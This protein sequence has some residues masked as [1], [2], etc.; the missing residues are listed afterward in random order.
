MKGCVLTLSL[1]LSFCG[2]SKTLIVD[3]KGSIPSIRHAI[4]SASPGDTIIVRPG[5][6]R[7]GNLT[8]N[9]P[10][11][12][13]GTGFPVLDGENKYEIMTVT[14]H[15]VT[16]T[17]F[18]L[19]NTGVASMQDV[20]AISSL[21]V[22]G[23]RII[24]NRFENTFFG[25][26]LAG[27]TGCLIENNTLKSNAESEHQLGNGIHCWK[28]DHIT[29]RRNTISGHRDGIY[30]EFVTRS[31]IVENQS[32]ENGRYGLHFM[33]SHD[34]EYLGNTFRNNGAGVAV[35]YS[36][37][38]RMVGNKFEEN[39]SASAYGLLLKDISDSHIEKNGFL[40]NTIG[41]HMEGSSR[42]NFTGN[43]FARNGWAIKIQ[44]SCEQNSYKENNFVE[45]TFDVAT[46]G[47]ISL[48][49]IEG[50]YWDKYEGYDLN[51]DGVGDVPYHP[52][53]LYGMIVE[54]MP[55]AIMLWRSFLVFLLDRTEKIVP[56]VT[57]ENL[58]DEHPAMKPVKS[59]LLL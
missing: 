14:A 44:A 3:L 43:E 51:R 24:N 15:D 36:K 54:K 53:S 35:M 18:R 25:I 32:F 30:F 6:Y 2:F 20:A 22:K 8:I 42:S 21:G 39:R 9:K 1:C 37:G 4:S 46:N 47:S 23:L 55:T 17:G 10:L 13:I 45:N 26:H 29:I 33:F 57:P 31:T 56:A 28:C 50:N 48:N 12:L 11:T 40:D 59:G 5:V 7:E 49:T 27:S 41:I 34:D 38:V 19:I 16:I 58:K 52:V